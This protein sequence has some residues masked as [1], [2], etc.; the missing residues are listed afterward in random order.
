LGVI[1]AGVVLAGCQTVPPE[2]PAAASAPGTRQTYTV[3][4]LTGEQCQTFL[5]PLGLDHITYAARGK[6]N[7]L[8]V[9]GTP[10]QL[11]AVET[12]LEV[13]DSHDDYCVETLGPA[14]RVRDLP[15]NR[16]IAAALGNLRIGTFHQLPGKDGGP[17]AI[18]DIQ[19]DTIL[20]FVPVR[21]RERLHT[22][23]TKDRT[24][25]SPPQSTLLPGRPKEH[26]AGMAVESTA[27]LSPAAPP[28][29]AP[30]D[31][32]L[33]NTESQERPRDTSV[34]P[35][36]AGMQT[37]TVLTLTEMATGADPEGGNRADAP[38]SEQGGGGAPPKTITIRLAPASKDAAA[39]GGRATTDKA[40]PS[41]GEDLLTM[42]LPETITLIQL[43][44]LVGKHV[45]L[46]YVYDPKE[47][48]SQPIALKL[49][50]KLQGEMRVK[51]LYAL[52]ETVLSFMNLAMIRQG[53][54]LV[55]VVP[56]EKALQTQPELVEVDADTV[57]VGDTVVTRVFDLQH[58]EVASVMA[59]LQN[60]QLSVAATGLDN[61]KLLLV[62]CHAG[63]MNRIEQLVE[64]IDRP[65]RPAECRFRRLSYVRATPLL[66][67]IRALAGEL[68]GI[69]LATPPA[70]QRPSGPG[71]AARP[72]T[73]PT[74]KPATAKP[75]VPMT[76]AKPS[77]APRA[78]EPADR[79]LV[80]LDT[81]ERTNRILMIGFAAELTLLEDL[82]DILDVAQEDPRAPHIYTLQHLEAQQAL[83]KLQKLEV[84]KS[85]PRGG[86]ASGAGA[87]S[88]PLTG[89]PLVAVLEATNQLL[90]KAAPDQHARIRE[91]LH[92]LDVA[93][94]D[95]RTIVAYRIQH[96]DVHAAQET[97]EE[98][99][100]VSVDA[101][102]SSFLAEPNRPA[103]QPR[104][105]PPGRGPAARVPITTPADRSRQKAPIVVS[106]STNALLVKAT[107]EQHA[108]IAA[109]LQYIDRYTPEEEWTYQVY[110]LESSSP[111]HL[112]SLLE[113]LIQE[114]TKD[115]DG[116]IEKITPK[117]PEP[118]TIVPDPN[119]FSLIVHASPKSQ[120]WI[121]GL[122]GRLD[123]RRPQVLIDVTLVEVTRTD[124]F[125]Y[126][127]NLVAGV[128]NPVIG[129]LVV[130]PI[131]R[132]DR[133]SRLEGGF[134]LLDQDGNP[135]G[136]TRAFYSDENVQMLLTAMQRK[137]YGRVLAKPK[138]LVDDGRKGQIVTTDTTTYV[139]ESI[140]IPQTGTPITTREF[141]P[142]EASI[143]LQITPHISEGNLLRLD[144]FLSRDDFGSRP[145]SGAPPDKATSEVI[146]T[147][148]V[149]DDNTVILGGL[150][151]LNQS[152]GG[153]KVPLLGDLPLVGTLFRSI[154]N[155]DI[156]KK[157]YVFLK[158]NIVRPYDDSG[159]ADLQ[160]I[161]AEHRDAFEQS[162]SDFQKLQSV[163]GIPSQPM[164][165]EGVLRDYQ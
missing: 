86:A 136:R 148:F 40:A 8:E 43:L 73:P 5:R 128:N 39:A 34:P 114:T 2:G 115:K 52:L 27:A 110:P 49:H 137:N 3:R 118:I 66:T 109:I 158:A 164:Q 79:R 46:N 155:S 50:G 72:S 99:D 20:A 97:L 1:L 104:S 135:T 12:V 134:N 28:V 61:S 4:G 11:K 67:K 108:R 81:D 23:L 45:G 96:I 147:V 107:P 150:V 106:E 129:N 117:T 87:D 165:P 119:T 10:S 82:I 116:K 44:D 70:A 123:Q 55:A 102:T 17:R 38:S 111:D 64:M 13:V 98:L 53:D 58:A 74:A 57:H 80:Y 127:L 113:R 161:S 163:P 146:T 32:A 19:G 131:Q 33:V 121:A 63:R 157:L 132:A 21:Y 126:D 152:K 84:L 133:G 162:E 24:V 59:L 71:P 41:N 154:D 26:P 100:L 125:E 89:E 94:T 85:S 29:A 130:D 138:V 153:S 9:Q 35:P 77:A 145:L 159:L 90:V 6:T 47:I 56:I 16:Q 42:T 37:P 88:E 54:N 93:P 91:S 141:V 30:N 95:T 151:K 122:I 78:A 68:N 25:M 101:P 75:P 51:N 140:Q 142:I 112:A 60:L 149:P 31:A 14:S 65:G 15:S 83:D 120:K 156:E 103:A 48:S 144:V 139:K 62:T 92:Y 124:T 69:S 105:G 76:A 18:I 143:E 22:V 36:S 7:V 160:E